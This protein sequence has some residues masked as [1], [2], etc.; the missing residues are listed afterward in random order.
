MKAM[1][2][3]AAEPGFEG[4]FEIRPATVRAPMQTDADGLV[5]Q[6]QPVTK[7]IRHDVLEY[8]FACKRIDEA[9]KIAGDRLQALITRAGIGGAQA[10]D[11]GNPKVDGGGK[12]DTLTDAVADAHKRLKKIREAMTE[13]FR[14][15]ELAIGDGKSLKE[16]A[17][18]WYADSGRYRPNQR[19]AEVYIA[20][21]FRDALDKLVGVLGVAR[22]SGLQEIRA[23]NNH[24]PLHQC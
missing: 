16:I 13:D 20:C 3:K 9:Q 4:K 19:H 5:V 8:E 18:L 21:R 2:K 6:V 22:G 12:S 10:I 1:R 15:L 23:W 11:Y 7:N 24:V 14:L 17:V